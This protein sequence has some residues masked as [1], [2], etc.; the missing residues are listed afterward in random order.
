MSVT[1]MRLRAVDIRGGADLTVVTMCL[2]QSPG[3]APLTQKMFN[4]IR[5]LVCLRSRNLEAVSL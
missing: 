3:A 5:I 1:Q 4:S 2:F